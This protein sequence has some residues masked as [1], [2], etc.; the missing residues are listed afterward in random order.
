MRSFRYEPDRD[1]VTRQAVRVVVM[2]PEDEVLLLRDTDPGCPDLHWWVTPGGG[3]DPGES[4]HQAAVR[5]LI[6]ETGLRIGTD[7]LIGPLANRLVRHGYSDQIFTQTEL[8]YAVEVERF[9]LDT[10]G[11]TPEEVITLT[12]ARWWPLVELSNTQEWIWPA[13]L[14]EL[15][16][17]A[18]QVPVP[19]SWELGQVDDES[20]RPI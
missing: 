11:L 6:E 2:T 5:E 16:R 3:I 9:D 14:V 4:D 18:R 7:Q 1:T 13:Q 19:P 12:G 15:V 8:F 20:P 17:R 10:S